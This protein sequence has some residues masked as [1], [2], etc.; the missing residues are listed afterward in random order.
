[1]LDPWKLNG[2]RTMHRWLAILTLVLLAAVPARAQ[3]RVDLAIVVSLDRSESIDADDARA[4]IE[5]LLYTLRH[6]RFRD[7]VASGPYGRVAL[8]VT[9]WSS[10]GNFEEI[11]P[12]TPIAGP[13]DAEAAA[14]VLELDFNRARDARHGTQTDIAFAI[15]VGIMKLAEIPWPANRQV[16]NVVA[17]GVSNIGRI[18]RVDRDR[19]IELGITVNGLIMGKGSQIEALTRYFKREVIGGPAAFIEKSTT[20]PEFSEAML[21]K[22]ILEMVRLRAPAV[23]ASGGPAG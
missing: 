15:E 13:A 2:S 6:G 18:A 9:T 20:P 22:M 14:Q 21:R 11:L 12:W 19:A 3:M 16:I 10:F 5:G 17:D 23:V 8:N 1:M 7:T 4:Q